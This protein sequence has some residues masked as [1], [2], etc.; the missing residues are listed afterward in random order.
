M[1]DGQ[2]EEPWAAT[3]DASWYNRPNVRSN[4][5]VHMSGRTVREG[6]MS[7]CGRS[8]LDDGLTWIPEDVPEHIR[9]RGNGCRQAWPTNGGDKR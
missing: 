7:K 9:C 2:P 8:I 6:V 1:A 5:V 4:K 3:R